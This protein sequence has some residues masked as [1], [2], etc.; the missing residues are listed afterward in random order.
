VYPVKLRG[1]C[2]ERQK[3]SREA[4]LLG[5]A[6]ILDNWLVHSPEDCFR[7]RENPKEGL[8]KVE[9]SREQLSDT[10]EKKNDIQSC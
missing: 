4:S 3:Y 5:N 1:G 9:A 8:T 6:Y 7:R 10:L 2:K